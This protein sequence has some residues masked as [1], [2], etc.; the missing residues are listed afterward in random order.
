MKSVD[1]DR[2]DRFGE[3]VAE[4]IHAGAEEL[5]IEY[6]DGYDEVCVMR[7]PI[8][9]GI[10]RFRSSSSEGIALREELFGIARRSR[11]LSIGG[12]AWGVRCRG[13]GSLGGGGCP[14]G[15]P[16]ARA[17]AGCEAKGDAGPPET[18]RP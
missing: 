17:P 6:K 3:V 13:R 11:C 8:G 9:F 15:N 16:P 2:P 7:G 10:A 4:A 5:D 12:Q 1:D 14:G 18:A